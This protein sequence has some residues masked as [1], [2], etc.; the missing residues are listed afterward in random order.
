MLVTS[1]HGTVSRA[2]A[3]DVSRALAGDKLH[4]EC[5]VFG[6]WNAPDAAALTALVEI[7]NAA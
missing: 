7:T 6:V 1:P 5:G 2:L 4:E 3:D